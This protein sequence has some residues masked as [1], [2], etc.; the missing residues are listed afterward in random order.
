MAQ[1][2]ILSDTP[3]RLIQKYR[4]ALNNAGIPVTSLIMFGSYAKGTAKP[5][6]D[7]DVCVVSPKFGVNRYDE[8]GI[9]MDI[10]YLVDTMLEPHPYSPEDL[11]DR[12]DPLAAEIRKYGKVIE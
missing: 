8:R 5:W 11:E 7:V 6:S 4:Q 10:S 9:L 1:K 12:Y 2:S 3:I